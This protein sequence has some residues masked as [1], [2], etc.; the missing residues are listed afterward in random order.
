LAATPKTETNDPDWT[1]GTKIGRAADGRYFVLDHRR[2]RQSPA[3]VERMLVNTASE[4]GRETEIS[5]PQDPGQAGKSQVAALIRA[6]EGYT[7]R[8][9]PETG[10]KVTR[11]GAFSAQAEAGNVYVLRGPW[12][13]DWFTALEAF[14][15]AKHDD[16]ADSTS[17][18]F[19]G[20]V[21]Q[22]AHGGF[23]DLIHQEN[24][25]TDERATP[26]A[27][28]PLIFEM[29]GGTEKIE[30]AGGEVVYEPGATRRFAARPEHS[31]TLRALGCRLLESA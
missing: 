4:D 27:E 17:R 14:P 7:A 26:T 16:D 11:F 1:A 12:N 21:M 15:D 6:L 8:A 3:V 10:D 22:G 19:S 30:M 29:P 31:I 25:A 13:E 5:L 24:A 2:D 28:R 20:F 9:S 18:A 23:L